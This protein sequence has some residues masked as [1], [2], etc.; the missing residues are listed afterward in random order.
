MR[1]EIF[2]IGTQH[3]RLAIRL[4]HGSIVEHYKCQYYHHTD[5]SSLRIRNFKPLVLKEITTLNT[6]K[7]HIDL[8]K[9]NI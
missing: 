2:S 3:K 8:T 7:L 1:A 5:R 9:I 4:P 6:A